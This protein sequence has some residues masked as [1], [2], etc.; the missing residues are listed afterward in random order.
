MDAVTI[1]NKGGGSAGGDAEDRVRAAL[2]AAGIKSDIEL[3]EGRRCAER[4]AEIVKAGASLV[5]ACGGDGTISAVAGALAGTEARLGVLPLGTLNHF[6]RDLGIPFDIDAAAKIIA[7]GHEQRV[8]VAELNGR[9][10]VNNSAIGLYPQMVLNRDAQRRHLGRSKWLAVIVASARTLAR[11]GHQRL[12]LTINDRPAVA[13]TPLLFVGNNDYQLELP[14]AGS[15]ES[16]DD[17]RLCV[18]VMRSKSRTGF[19]AATLRAL[20]GRTKGDDMARLEGVTTLRVDSHRSLLGVAVDGEMLHLKPPLDYRI[21]PG[22]LRVIA[23][24]A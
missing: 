8:D 7:G 5:I 9:P 1:I 24:K 6:A 12:R 18:L 15:R 11:Y 13:D 10:F 21:R 3:V 17:G 20:L 22:A 4:A 19:L 23:P 16:L 2:D 14:N